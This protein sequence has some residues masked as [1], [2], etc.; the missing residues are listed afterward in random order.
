MLRCTSAVDFTI[1]CQEEWIGTDTSPLD[2]NEAIDWMI[3]D[4]LMPQSMSVGNS[5]FV[6]RPGLRDSKISRPR[7]SVTGMLKIESNQFFIAIE[8][9][10]WFVSMNKQW[11]NR[12][13]GNSKM[14]GILI[15]SRWMR[16]VFLIDCYFSYWNRL[17][18]SLLLE[19]SN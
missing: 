11:C 18:P 2:K 5:S 10:T 4:F 3:F 7:F 8:L 6:V 9:K 13:F 14:M 15:N 16:L 19:V 12:E 1:V 17:S